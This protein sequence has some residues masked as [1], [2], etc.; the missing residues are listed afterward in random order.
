MVKAS[1]Y[2]MDKF[3]WGEAEQYHSI[4][5]NDKKYRLFDIITI[6]TKSNQTVKGMIVF[7]AQDQVDIMGDDDSKT[8]ALDQIKTIIR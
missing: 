3:D 5:L 1:D 6:I 8:V 2:F 7:I 4:E